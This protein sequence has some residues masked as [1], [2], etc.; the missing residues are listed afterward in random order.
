MVVKDKILIHSLVFSPDGVSTAYLYNDIALKFIEE[1]Y[2]VVVLTTTP[3][4]NILQTE[5]DKQPLRPKLGGLYYVSNFHGVKVIHITQKKFKNSILRILGFVYW[6]FLAFFLGLSEKNVKVILSPSPP[7]S[8][9]VINWAIGKIKGAKIIY[10]VQEIYPDFLINQGKLKIGFVISL[11]KSIERFVYNRSDAVTTIDEIFAQTILPRFDHQEKL[12]IIPNFVDTGLFRPISREDLLLD[13]YVFPSK[14]DVLKIM[15]AG[16]LGHAQDWM[17]LIELAKSLLTEKVEFWIIGEGVM[18][19]FLEDQIS[20]FNLHNIHL[21][22]YQN[23]DSMPSL[24]AY[25]DLHFIFMSPEMEGQ[26]FP[27]KVYSILACAKPIMVISG[28]ST[29]IY[30]FLKPLNCA[31][32]ISERRVDQQRGEMLQLIMRLQDNKSKLLEMGITG[33]NY[34]QKLYTKDVIT[35]QY[36]T[37]VAKLLQR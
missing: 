9:G 2:E 31:F 27:S 24:I 26:G 5:L 25:A 3:H 4:Y 7:L 22:S 17:P 23:R 14:P 19:T 35:K 18:K 6:H 15:Y 1:G 16:N 29:P 33:F 12:S 8:I 13:E 34:I 20:K 11:L 32:L 30:N 36:V 28:E 10:N 37:L 21:V